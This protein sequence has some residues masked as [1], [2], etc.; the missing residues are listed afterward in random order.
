MNAPEAPEP[1]TART[2]PYEVDDE[3]Q[4]AL[5]RFTLLINA[6]DPAKALAG[7]LDMD[8]GIRAHGARALRGVGPVVLTDFRGPDTPAD[9][10]QAREV[11]LFELLTAAALAREPLGVC[12]ELLTGLADEGADDIAMIAVRTGVAE[13]G[14]PS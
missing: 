1:A 10:L 11:A 3:V 2:D 12:D 4:H 13:A 6:T 9:P 5:D 14:A 8:T 7:T